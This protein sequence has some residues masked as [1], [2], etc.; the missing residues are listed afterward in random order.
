MIR[1]PK[2]HTSIGNWNNSLRQQGVWNVLRWSK[3]LLQEVPS[4]LFGWHPPRQEMLDR[5]LTNWAASQMTASP[6]QC[7]LSH[8][9]QKCQLAG[10]GC[11]TP[12]VPIAASLVPVMA[13]CG[14]GNAAPQ[15]KCFQLLSWQWWCTLVCDIPTSNGSNPML[16]QCVPPTCGSSYEMKVKWRLWPRQCWIDSTMN[17]GYSESEATGQTR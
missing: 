10:Q 15:R 4:D 8:K 17:A 9:F 16:S 5:L 6:Q 14:Q 2:D 1:A 7:R 3:Q 11:T 12:V 13:G